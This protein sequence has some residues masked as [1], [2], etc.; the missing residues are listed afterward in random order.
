MNLRVVTASLIL[1]PVA[2]D[3][4]ALLPRA[5]ARSSPCPF[6][7]RS[8]YMTCSPGAS[9]PVRS[10]FLTVRKQT[11]IP[12]SPSPTDCRMSYRSVP[13]PLRGL[14]KAGFAGVDPDGIDSV[15]KV[16]RPASRPKERSR[17]ACSRRPAYS[18]PNRTGFPLS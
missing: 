1:P 18:D 14:L 5:A 6:K 10:R 3:V 7:S 4:A 17:R 11:I 13:T 2:D 15:E 16:L 8:S 12:V 9:K